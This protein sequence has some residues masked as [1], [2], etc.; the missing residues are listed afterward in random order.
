MILV[1][2]RQCTLIIIISYTTSKC[3]IPQYHRVNKIRQH[4][5]PRVRLELFLSE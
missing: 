5:C 1:R 4:L 3:K 2:S